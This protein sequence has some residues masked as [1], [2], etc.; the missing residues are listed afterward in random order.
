MTDNFLIP[1]V[2]ESTSRGERAYDLFSR[3]MK[4]RIVFF[5]GVVTE[6]MA[7]IL[8]GQLLF[9]ESQDP[10]APINMY[11]HSPGGSV[12]AGMAIYDTMQFIQCPV[13]TM[14]IGQAASM[15]SFIANAGEPGHRYIL[16][17]A[18]TMVHQPSAG[19]SGQ[20]T[21]IQIHATEVLRIKDRL[22]S[23]YERHN[24][25]GLSKDKIMELLERDKFLS[26]EETVELGFADHVVT[27]REQFE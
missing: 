19:Y 10:V 25:A 23:L 22:N 14:V 8:V 6:D 24:S 2:V 9:L 26:A 5:R 3:L 7:D 15:G 13:Y 11:V 20:A 12:T 27:S 21:D 16:E 4:E 17:N 18:R 1:T